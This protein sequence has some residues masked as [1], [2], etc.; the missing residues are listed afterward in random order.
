MDGLGIDLGNR[1]ERH[2]EP[3]TDFFGL[4]VEGLG[5]PNIASDLW[6]IHNQTGRVI[7]GPEDTYTIPPDMLHMHPGQG[8]LLRHRSLDLPKA[9][10]IHKLQVDSSIER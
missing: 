5:S 7:R 9:G 3:K 4:A 10:K 2:T 6:V 1:F 8:G